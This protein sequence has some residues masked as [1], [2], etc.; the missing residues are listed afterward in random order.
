MK[1]YILSIALVIAA[2]VLG[3]SPAKAVTIDFESLMRVNE[4]ANH[5]LLSYSEDGFTLSNSVGQT[6][7]FMTFGTLHSKFSGSTALMHIGHAIQ[8]DLTRTGGGSFSLHS[9]DLAEFFGSGET[10]PVTFIG[11]L[12]G[13]GTVTNIFTLDGVAFGAETF[14]FTGFD[15][16][17]KVSWTS[18][19]SFQSDI[20][21]IDNIVVNTSTSVPEPASLGLMGLGLAGLA[22]IRRGRQQ[23]RG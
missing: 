14:T 23:Q 20:R 17:T 4:L 7:P 5:H 1:N 8:T 18:F 22:W 15:S 10:T 21:Q 16:V 11:D 2:L 6:N 13:G 19:T 3:T 12:T 9:I